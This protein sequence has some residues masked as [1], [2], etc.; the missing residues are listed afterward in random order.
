MKKTKNKAE[1]KGKAKAKA[2]GKGYVAYGGYQ[3]DY[4]N[5][6]SWYESEWKVVQDFTKVTT[7]G[8]PLAF[9]EHDNP[10]EE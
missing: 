4:G 7:D 10:N 9:L 6:S 2:E 1:P 5:D 3:G 8:D